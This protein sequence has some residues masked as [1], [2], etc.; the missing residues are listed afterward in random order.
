LGFH[1]K[2]A[3]PKGKQ[4]EGILA[5]TFRFVKFFC[6]HFKK[7]LDCD[8]VKK[9][10]RV[11]LLLIFLSLF[12]TSCSFSKQEKSGL[13]IFSQPQA[14]VFLNG[15]NIGQTPY[16]SKELKIGDYDL[17]I[18]TGSASWQTKIELN[19]GALTVVNRQLSSGN[20]FD[21]QGEILTL[22]DGKGLA[23][24]SNPPGAQVKI[25]D[26]E[27]GVSPLILPDQKE[28][29]YRIGLFKNGYLSRSVAVQVNS[30]FKTVVHVDLAQDFSKAEN[31]ES[32]SLISKSVVI[33]AT[34]TGWL[35][36]RSE[37]NLQGE[38][39]AKVNTGESFSLLEEKDSWYKILLKDGKEGWVSSQYATIQ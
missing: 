37:P 24:T 28:G 32:K 29:S 30:N 13:Q 5:K 6:I 18:A 38:E 21:E 25:D 9:V 4:R 27:K 36:V 20:F 15:E 14:E 11:F 35:R 34:P 7:S 33:S 12:L 1:N 22:E 2:T 17:K 31:E 26:Q 3:Y 23:V 10:K 16:L 19:G 39:V 8:M